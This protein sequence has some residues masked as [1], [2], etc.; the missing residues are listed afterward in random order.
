MPSGENVVILQPSDEGVFY[1]CERQAD[2]GI[3]TGAVQTYLDVN[4]SGGQGNEAAE[5]ILERVLR[6]QWGGA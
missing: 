6:K 2:G 3:A 4:A 1:Q 5:K